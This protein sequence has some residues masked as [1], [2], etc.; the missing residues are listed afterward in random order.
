MYRQLDTFFGVSGCFIDGLFGHMYDA[1]LDGQSGEQMAGC[2]ESMAA[3]KTL[4]D[5]KISF[6]TQLSFGNFPGFGETQLFIWYKFFGS[7]LYCCFCRF[8]IQDFYLI[9]LLISANCLLL[10]ITSPYA[11]KSPSNTLLASS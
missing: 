1:G 8:S 9:R 7:C 3:D 10:S 11:S 5:F 4:Y 6:F 2:P